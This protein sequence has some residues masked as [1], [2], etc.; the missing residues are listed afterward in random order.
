MEQDNGIT[1]TGE[2]NPKALIRRQTGSEKGADPGQQI[3]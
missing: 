1:T 3:N 2:P